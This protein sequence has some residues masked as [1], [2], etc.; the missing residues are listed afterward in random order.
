[1]LL[2]GCAADGGGRGGGTR[3]CLRSPAIVVK[4]LGGAAEGSLLRFG[5]TEGAVRLRAA[6]AARAA[7]RAAHEAE[8]AGQPLLLPA[9]VPGGLAVAGLAG[10]ARAGVFWWVACG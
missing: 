9:T 3:G 7:A 10:A 8:V 6:E 2:D 5:A 1:M 4:G